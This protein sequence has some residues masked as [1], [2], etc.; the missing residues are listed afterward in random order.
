MTT[1]GMLIDDGLVERIGSFLSARKSMTGIT[2]LIIELSRSLRIS[3]TGIV[4]S[5]FCNGCNRME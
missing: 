4:N 1:I 5:E 2:R 3:V